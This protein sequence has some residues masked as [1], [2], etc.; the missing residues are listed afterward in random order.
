[1]LF[2]FLSF[3]FSVTLL[4]SD[5][6]AQTVC[7]NPKIN[8]D[9]LGLYQKPGRQFD[10]RR[11]TGD[12][13]KDSACAANLTQI[14][15]TIIPK[16]NFEY[17]SW[18]GEFRFKFFTPTMGS[19]FDLCLDERFV[20]QLAPG[21]CSCFLTADNEVTTAGHCFGQGSSYGDRK[22]RCQ[23][24]YIVFGFNQDSVK[25]GYKFKSDQVYD[26]NDVDK[27]DG[28]NDPTKGLDITRVQLYNSA[29]HSKR[30]PMDVSKMKSKA[31]PGLGRELCMIGSPLGAPLK[32]A[33]GQVKE[34]QNQTIAGNDVRLIKSDMDGMMGASG[35]M[36]VD[37]L[38][39]DLV[40]IY[41][42]GQVDLADNS[43][44][45]PSIN[46]MLGASVRESIGRSNIDRMLGKNQS[47]L[48]DAGNSKKL[49][50]VPSRHDANGS[51]LETIMFVG[52]FPDS[53]FNKSRAGSQ[54]QGVK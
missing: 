38:S 44:G 26:C 42:S 34:I 24:S 39:G 20:G 30:K 21:T 36:V 18:K 7:M 27:R 19:R 35:S 22:K 16:D 50:Q 46:E 6:V 43:D 23:N 49:C 37:C 25:N 51:R 40:G 5:A 11:E 13:S 31:P 28:K 52:D 10:S 4:S 8:Y 14:A 1:M 15:C 29:G 32:V 17:N 41:L 45:M 12:Y 9:V 54:A 2:S 47:S 3:V 53:P 33:L 48:Q